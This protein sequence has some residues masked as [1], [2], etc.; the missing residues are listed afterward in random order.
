MKKVTLLLM[1][2][3]L[4]AAAGCKSGKPADGQPTDIQQKVDEYAEFSLTSD[5]I[6]TLS[7]NEKELVKLFIEIGQVMDDIYWDEYFGQANRASLDTLA[8][9]ALRAFAQI[10]YG[11]WDRLDAERPFLPGYGERPAGCNFYPTDMTKEE[12]NAL[13]DPLK[14]S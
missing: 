3:T 6:Q 11:A 5:L 10:H 2:A 14:D 13:A 9:P 7:P 12:F 4:L 8:D 1:A